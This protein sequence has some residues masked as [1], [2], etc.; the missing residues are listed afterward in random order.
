MGAF[1]GAA[2]AGRCFVMDGI[3]A[4]LQGAIDHVIQRFAEVVVGLEGSAAARSRATGSDFGEQTRFCCHVAAQGFGSWPTRAWLA[5][6]LTTAERA[7]VSQRAGQRG[8]QP[9]P[10]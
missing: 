10:E 7:A 2:A 5:R 9:A 3:L 4:G 1:E 6:A 8:C